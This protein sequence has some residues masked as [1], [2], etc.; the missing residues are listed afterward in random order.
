MAS[1][2]TQF[3]IVPAE[4]V[5]KA[6]RGRKAS[7]DPDMMAAAEA[8]CDAG[9][10]NAL[11]LDQYVAP[12]EDAKQTIGQNI[13]KHMNEAI[14]RA[15]GLPDEVSYGINWAPQQDGSYLPQVSLLVK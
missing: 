7:Y 6:R 9:V 10:G 2:S 8:L 14:K 15:S 5:V 13:R 4:Q 1:K 3:N 12:D 11:V